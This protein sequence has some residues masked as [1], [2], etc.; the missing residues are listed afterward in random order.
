MEPL[1]VVVVGGGNAALCAALAA[2]ETGARVL[3]LEAAPASEEAI[4]DLPPVP[5]V[6]LTAA[7]RTCKSSFR[8]EGLMIDKTNW[9]NTIDTPSFEAY[10]A[11]CGITFRRLADRYRCGGAGCLRQIDPWA[12][13]HR[14]TGGWLFLF[15]LSRRIGIDLWRCF[16]SDREGPPRRIVLAS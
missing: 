5:C 13:R 6:F 15:Q 11:T 3:V 1:E 9:A 16:R 2:R 10:A 12:V 8:T 14:R 4:P 7:S